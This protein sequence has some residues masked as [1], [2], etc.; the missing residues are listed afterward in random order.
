MVVPTVD[1][2]AKQLAEVSGAQNVDP[3]HP[4][5]LISDVD[6]LDLME[7]LYGFQN[8]YPSIPADESLFA[9]MDESTTLNT[10]HE[11]LVKLVPNGTGQGNNE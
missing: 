4:I 8:D 3:S 2:I 10:I 11:R 6:S 7:W 9:E 5:Q 1:E